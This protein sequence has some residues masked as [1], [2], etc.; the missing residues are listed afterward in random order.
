M[1]SDEKPKNLEEN[2][3]IFLQKYW[4][5]SENIDRPYEP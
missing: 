1:Q 5:N 3:N 4:L 2:D